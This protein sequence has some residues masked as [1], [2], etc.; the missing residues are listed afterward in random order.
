MKFPNALDN[1]LPAFL[2]IA[3]NRLNSEVKSAALKVV[4]IEVVSIGLDPLCFGS[5][6]VNVVQTH[7]QD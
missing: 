6:L 1:I 3:V 4:L 7:R 5:Y 2:D